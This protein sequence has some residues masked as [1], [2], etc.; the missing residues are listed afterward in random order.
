[1]V[2]MVETEM[3]PLYITGVGSRKVKPFFPNLATIISRRA[4]ELGYILRTGDAIGMDRGFREGV[5]DTSL[6]H[7]YS[8]KKLPWAIHGPSCELWDEAI[9]IVS[10]IHPA[11]HKCDPYTR[12]LHGR[13][14]FQV[15]GEDLNTPSELYVCYAPP[16]GTDRKAVSG[17]TNTSYQVARDWGI[18]IF[19]IYFKEDFN[20]L[21]EVLGIQRNNKHIS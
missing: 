15:I 6:K 14:V 21:C 18:P 12:M 7:V 5:I 16:L 13:N 8:A 20:R 17:G 19:N 9:A 4:C 2:Q 1:M 11:W 10:A 3:C